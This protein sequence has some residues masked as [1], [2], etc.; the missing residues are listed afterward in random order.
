MIYKKIRGIVA[1][2]KGD[3]K[4][5]K[6]DFELQREVYELKQKL[7]SQENEYNV[8]LNTVVKECAILNDTRHRLEKENAEL[9]DKYL[10]QV[11]INLQLAKGINDEH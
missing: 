8:N 10:N 1:G 6:R 5:E 2:T 7:K 4:L 3:K 11:V 9:K